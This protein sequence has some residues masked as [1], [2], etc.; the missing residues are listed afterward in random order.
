MAVN[1]EAVATPLAFV[2]AFAVVDPLANVPLAPVPGAVN[3]TVIPLTGLLLASLTVAASAVPKFVF[4]DV[5]CGVPA[6]AV[7]LAGVEA[8][9]VNVNVVV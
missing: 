6:V 4:T 1:V 8:F 9:T 7:M 5:L 3:V 2:V